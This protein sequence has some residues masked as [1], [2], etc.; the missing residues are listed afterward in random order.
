MVNLNN[1]IVDKIFYF[2]ETVTIYSI[3]YF[4]AKQYN[5]NMLHVL[6]NLNK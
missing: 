2:Y 4:I 6:S 5:E 1:L 3:D